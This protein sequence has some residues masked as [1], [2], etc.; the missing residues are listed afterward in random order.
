[1]SW[2][3]R[4]ACEITWCT[5]TIKLTVRHLITRHDLILSNDRILQLINLELVAVL[6]SFQKKIIAY[7]RRRLDFPPKSEEAS[8]LVTRRIVHARPCSQH[9]RTRWRASSLVVVLLQTGGLRLC[10]Y[11]KQRVCYPEFSHQLSITQQ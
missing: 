7:R 2:K 9:D 5:K 6:N 3:V 8:R 1:M 4:V 11:T 10:V